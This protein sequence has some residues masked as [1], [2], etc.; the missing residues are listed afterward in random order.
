VVYLL[1]DGRD[2]MVSYFHHHNALYP[3]VDFAT[4]VRTAPKLMAKWHVH[5][6]A[7]QRNP[8]GAE[9]ILVKYE[10][11]HRDPVTE[12]RRICTFAGIA[13]DDAQLEQAARNASFSNQQRREKQQGWSNPEWPKGQAFVRRGVVGSHRDEMSAEVLAAFLAEAGPTLRRFGYPVPTRGA[14]LASFPTPET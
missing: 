5:A 9:I 10:D 14:D 8:F 6:E 1:R 11:L 7:W 3:P 13:A 2:A 4:L 12:L